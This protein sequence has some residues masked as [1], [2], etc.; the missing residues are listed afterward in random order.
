MP[1][2]TMSSTTNSPLFETP[3]AAITMP[4]IHWISLRARERR[5]ALCNVPVTSSATFKLP[6][7]FTRAVASSSITRS[8]SSRYD[9]LQCA[10][11]LAHS[12]KQ[13]FSEPWR[14]RQNQLVRCVV[15]QHVRFQSHVLV[16][17]TN[18]ERLWKTFE[19]K[20]LR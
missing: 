2:N 7:S 18:N 13:W 14:N 12:A 10:C 16:D 3:H 19:T 17:C 20:N 5:A 9:F 11:A 8:L 4:A 15:L 1:A 6:V